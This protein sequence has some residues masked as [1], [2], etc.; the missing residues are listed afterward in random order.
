MT[1]VD[2]SYAIMEG[3]NYVARKVGLPEVDH[4]KTMEY[5]ATPIDEFCRGLLGDYKPEW[6]TLY[7]SQSE[8]LEREFV[9][10]F[11]D[12]V[13]TLKSL[14][15]MGVKVAMASNR[16]NPVLVSERTGLVKYFDLIVG[17][18]V[19]FGTIKYKPAP[20][21]LIKTLEYFEIPAES[22]IYVGDSEIDI[23]TALAANIRAVGITKGNFSHEEF[24]KM[25]AWKTIDELQKLL[26]IVERDGE[27]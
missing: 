22:A 11:P 2:S 6:I 27:L 26:S 13:S 12:T 14:K 21:M 16:E 4:A 10:P 9:K 17:A 7:R 18:R 15:A 20:D 8:R 23:K 19:P 3:F 25:G 1:I 5:I 24:S